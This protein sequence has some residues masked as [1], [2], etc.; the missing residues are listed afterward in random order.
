[1]RK[2][3][4]AA[5]AITALITPTFASETNPT[6]LE[7]WYFIYHQYDV[8]S[9][10]WGKYADNR[11]AEKLVIENTED[12]IVTEQHRQTEGLLRETWTVLNN[13]CVIRFDRESERGDD[14]IKLFY[15]NSISRNINT[16]T[17]SQSNLFIILKA[18]QPA[19]P[20]KHAAAMCQTKTRDMYF[21]W[22][23]PRGV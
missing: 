14:F 20:N 23:S 17:N 22:S 1:M 8:T 2:W 9:Q 19:E 18:V 6:L 5:V 4:L 10:P 16:E 3:L 7:T 12:R 15:L 11:D 21:D 13:N